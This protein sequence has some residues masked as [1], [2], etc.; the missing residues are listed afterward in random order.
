MRRNRVTETD[1]NLHRDASFL[2]E[3]QEIDPH[4]FVIGIF[5]DA[6]RGDTL[7]VKEQPVVC[8]GGCADF[9]KSRFKANRIVFTLGKEIRISRGTVCLVGPEFK[10]QCSL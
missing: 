3:P 7:R 1:V 4:A 9:L 8:D 6:L 5:L 2:E 10:E